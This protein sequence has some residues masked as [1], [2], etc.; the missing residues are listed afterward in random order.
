MTVE[1]QETPVETKSKRVLLVEDS[2]ATQDLVELML[3]AAGH[4]ITISGTGKDALAELEKRDFDVVLCDFH[5]P[6]VTG[7]DV[8]N[9]FLETLGDRP[10]P[11]FV[12]ITG[13]VRG[14]LS[15]RANCEVF[16]RVIPKPLDID[17]IQELIKNPAP[18]VAS[19]V[20]PN[21]RRTR[22]AIEQLGLAF[23]HWPHVSGPAPSP[24]LEK[25]DA[26]IVN[27]N[28]DLDKL[29]AIPGANMLPV[30]DETGELGLK[31]DLDLSALA[32]DDISKVSSLVD[33][34]H[35]KRAKIHTDLLRSTEPAD[36][37]LC[38]M[39]L[40]GGKL[41]PWLTHMHSGLAAWNTLADPDQMNPLLTRLKK[42]NLISTAFFERIQI[43]PGCQSGTLIVREECPECGSSD[44]EEDNY[45]HHFRCA[46]QAPEQE[47]RSGNDLV[48][49][50]CRRELTHFGR[51][52][53]RPGVMTR[54]RTCTTATSEPAVSF[55][56]TSCLT[57]TPAD[58][59]AVNDILAAEIT[60]AGISY[61]GSGRSYLG[62]AQS[63]LRFGDFPL[64]LTIALNRAAKAYNETK[65][66]FTLGYISYERL[67]EINSA[68]QARDAR[69][70]WF[71]TF[72]QSL[73]DHAFLTQGRSNDFFLMSGVAA[74]DSKDRLSAAK[75]SA[76]KVVRQNLD[77]RFQL[78]GPDDLV[79]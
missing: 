28:K 45:L 57:K 23:L 16:D 14:L 21:L 7:L 15:D 33:L 53:D 74:E 72:K 24:G 4:E 35:D 68:R 2:S 17:Q 42:D 75:T 36:R 6:D 43:C 3:T 26:I 62:P 38:R 11:S 69:G 10:R 19:Y 39:F 13:D 22:P 12:A 52:Y 67:A 34:F 55:V 48:C 73:D 32:L 63:V 40:S 78:F 79:K 76:D 77:C 31:A 51:D 37:L 20:T 60:E 71:E 58:D 18:H 30:L 8:A 61:L 49:P 27:E 25:I 66:P 65:E 44:L 56:C 1:V 47:F 41:T 5:L 29:W 50:K 9:R 54:C 70:L 59:M 64:E 46:Y